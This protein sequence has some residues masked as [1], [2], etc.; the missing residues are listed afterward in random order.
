MMD[1][2]SNEGFI[3][4]HC[5]E[6]AVKGTVPP[7]CVIHSKLDKTASA[8]DTLESISQDPSIWSKG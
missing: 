4:I 7:V 1:K 2:K 5:G 8:E 3:C 6:P